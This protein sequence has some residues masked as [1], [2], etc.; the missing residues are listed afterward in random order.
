MPIIISNLDLT[1]RFVYLYKYS[2]E[3]MNSQMNERNNGFRY[4]RM[5]AI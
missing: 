1:Y 5:E 3:N 4:L 2:T